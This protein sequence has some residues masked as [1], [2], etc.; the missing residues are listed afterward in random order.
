MST[1]KMCQH[2]YSDIRLT[3]DGV[4]RGVDN[5]QYCQSGIKH[6]PMPMVKT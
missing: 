3:P 1:A 4:W 2:C 6:K 5:D